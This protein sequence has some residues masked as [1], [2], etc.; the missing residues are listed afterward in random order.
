MTSLDVLRN[1]E[2][3]NDKM[4]SNLILV[5]DD[6]MRSLHWPHLLKSSQKNTSSSLYWK[7]VE[8][9]YAYKNMFIIK[10]NSCDEKWKEKN[11]QRH[12]FKL[13][14]TLWR[15]GWRCYAGKLL[16][17]KTKSRCFFSSWKYGIISQ[18]WKNW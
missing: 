18:I 16:N 9:L 7:I 2:K 3:Y 12:N 15:E 4:K 17:L 1:F 13:S 6:K 8:Y 10:M 5:V 14:C 11:F